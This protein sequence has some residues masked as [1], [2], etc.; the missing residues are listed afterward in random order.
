[1]E[2]PPLFGEDQVTTQRAAVIAA[3]P[4]SDDIE[5]DCSLL[6]NL[7]AKTFYR[8]PRNLTTIFIAIGERAR[9]KLTIP[10]SESYPQSTLPSY[11]QIVT[12][13]DVDPSLSYADVA[14]R[15]STTLE[16]SLS[17]LIRV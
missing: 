9:T 8:A 1:M 6:K 15:L 14:T 12:V 11:I 7:F 17:Q 4:Y 16:A 13:E 5:K 2:E 3:N 10:L